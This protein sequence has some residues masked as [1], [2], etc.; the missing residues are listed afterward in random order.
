MTAIVSIYVGSAVYALVRYV[1]FAPKNAESIP[2]FI[3]N[4]GISMAAAIC[5]AVGFFQ[6]WRLGRGRAVSPAPSVWFRAG[7]FGAVWHIPMSLVVLRP[8]YF[9]EFFRAPDASMPGRLSFEGE[10]VFLLGGATAALLF[11]LL[12]PQWSGVA[13]RRIAIAAMATLLGHVLTMGYCRGLN[14][15]ASHAYLPPMWLLSVVA[16]V[17]G[18]WWLV[19]DQ[20]NGGGA[21]S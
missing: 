13:R 17:L 16:V 11:L 12:R 3:L 20:Q 6:A 15:N 2:V 18:L 9:K 10:M 8:E 21:P 14:I 19:R 7:T 4:K 5:L 1:A